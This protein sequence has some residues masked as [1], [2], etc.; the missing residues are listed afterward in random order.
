MT[1]ALVVVDMQE[2]FCTSR[3]PFLRFISALVGEAETA[4]YLARLEHT[5]IPNIALLLDRARR[6]GDMVVITEFGSP[7]DGA[8]LPP[9]AQRHNEMARGLTG[10]TIY[11]ALTD[12]A[13]RTI[14]ALKPTPS[15]LTVRRSTSGPLA[16][17][18]VRGAMLARGV[19]HVVVTGVATDVC[20]TGWTRELAD[21]GFDVS[22]PSDAV[23]SPVSACHDSALATAI[24][25][26]ALLTE[27]RA[28]LP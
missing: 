17:T 13:A 8:G 20:V 6:R 15:D 21:S 18:D 4:D 9:W 10:E 7:V 2:Y 28:L 27:T 19:D 12:P 14:T 25:A 23:A 3:H 16:G 26:F 24:P 11:H 22:V 1:D 5:V